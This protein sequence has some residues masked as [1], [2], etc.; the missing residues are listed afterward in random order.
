MEKL[1]QVNIFCHAGTGI[2]LGH[3]TRCISIWD[4]IK[5]FAIF[6][7]K[8]HIISDIPIIISNKNLIPN[9]IDIKNVVNLNINS[10]FIEQ[11]QIFILDFN[12]NIIDD[13]FIN[14]FINNKNIKII[15]EVD[16]LLKYEKSINYF[17]MPTF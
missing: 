6:K 10:E 2:G 9:F 5:N 15:I 12:E 16:S 8:L 1:I 13:N 4:E 3:L 11:K 7:I 14:L 17:F